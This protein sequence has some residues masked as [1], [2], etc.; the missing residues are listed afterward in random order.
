[1]PMWEQDTDDYYY[2]PSLPSELPAET[3]TTTFTGYVAVI[4]FENV[5]FTIPDGQ[6]E[7]E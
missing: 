7:D 1:M 2:V 6:L 4:T 5:N 3:P